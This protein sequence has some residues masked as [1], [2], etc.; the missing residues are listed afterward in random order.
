MTL[1]RQGELL[2]HMRRVGCF[3]ERITRFYAA[4]IVLAL[5]YLHNL[6]IIHRYANANF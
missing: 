5:E 6:G 2:N 3:D 4:E 1:A